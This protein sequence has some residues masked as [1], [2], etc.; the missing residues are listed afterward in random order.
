[1][2]YIAI[3]G[4]ST[5]IGYSLCKVFLDHGCTV[6]GSVRKKS[7]AERLHDELG[8]HFYPLL[9]DVTDYEAV[10][11][12]AHY[13][14]EVIGNDSLSCLINNSGIAVTGPTMLLS[15]EDYKRQFEVNLFGHIAVTKAY[16]PL[17]GA[18]K[19]SPFKPGK[20][21]NISS[22]SG[23][24]AYPFMG[25]YCTSKFALGAFTDAL[26]RELLLYNIDVI[27]I[28]PGAIK[29]PIWNKSTN[30]P[31][32]VLESD[33]GPALDKFRKFVG[34]AAKNGM[35]ADDLARKIYKVYEKTNPKTRY[36]FMNKKFTN[37]LL[38]QYLFSPRM[39]DWL[40]RKM[41]FQNS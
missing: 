13:I 24:I 11:G 1:M 33:F 39:V 6:F 35:E 5:G 28:E 18:S 22:I 38:M 26:R 40:N 31:K 3:T 29:T 34:N 17:L 16:L 21:L 8:D 15:V 36:V 12:S 37:F 7:D 23:R 20:I 2:K 10:Y 4:V 41:F 25:P 27:S 30:I 19:S 14:S 9:F 32:E